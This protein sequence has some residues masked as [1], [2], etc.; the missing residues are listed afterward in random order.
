MLL[1]IFLLSQK[2]EKTK[3]M[4][5]AQNESDVYS[6]YNHSQLYLGCCLAFNRYTFFITFWLCRKK[7]RTKKRRKIR[8]WKIFILKRSIFQYVR[9]FVVTIANNKAP[10]HVLIFPIAGCFCAHLILKYVFFFVEHSCVVAQ[11]PQN[12][13]A[14]T[15]CDYVHYF[16]GDG[17]NSN[18]INIFE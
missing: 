8:I 1:S 6:I 3:K 17:D 10:F 16:S 13:W 9:A 5:L 2:E 14:L 15:L 7:S 11:I 18:Q 12:K 4:L